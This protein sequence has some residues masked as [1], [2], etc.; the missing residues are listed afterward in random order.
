MKK[1][2]GFTK[3]FAFMIKYVG[4][5]LILFIEIFGII[6]KIKA[7]GSQYWWIIVFSV[8]LIAVSAIVYFTFFKNAYTGANEDELLLE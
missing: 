3:I 4:P 5:L 1:V 7:N 6:G 8:L 2:G